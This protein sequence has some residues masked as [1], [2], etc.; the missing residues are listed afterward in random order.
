MKKFY[1]ILSLLFLTIV[2]FSITS[3]VLE[4]NAEAIRPRYIRTTSSGST[5][6]YIGQA[7][8]NRSWDYY[9]L[10]SDI[11]AAAD[12]GITTSAWKVQ[13]DAGSID[14][15]FSDA[16]M[17]SLNQSSGTIQAAG[18]GTANMNTGITFNGGW[19]D[20]NGGISFPGYGGNDSKMLHRIIFRVENSAS[21]STGEFLVANRSGVGSIIIFAQSLTTFRVTI[22]NGTTYSTIVTPPQGIGVGDHIL[23]I[24]TTD[25]ANS[26]VNERVNSEFYMDGTYVGGAEHTSDLASYPN[27]DGLSLGGALSTGTTPL[28][29]RTVFFIGQ[30]SG[31][32]LN[33]WFTGA[34]EHYADCVALGLCIDRATNT[35]RGINRGLPPGYDSGITNIVQSSL[36]ADGRTRTGWGVVIFSGFNNTTS[37]VLYVHHCGCSYN[38]SACRGAF[39]GAATTDP[40][41]EEYDTNGVHVYMDP[42]YT[43][44]TDCAVAGGGNGWL[45]SNSTNGDYQLMYEDAVITYLW[46]TFNISQTFCV[47]RSNGASWCN[48]MGAV[49]PYLYS[50]VV[51]TIGYLPG[52]LNGG[53]GMTATIAYGRT[54]IYVSHNSNDPTVAVDYA[55]WTVPEALQRN[56]GIDAGPNP[57]I[58]GGKGWCI[59]T[60]GGTGGVTADG[61]I[62]VTCGCGA[63]AS[64]YDSG[65]A[66]G[67]C[68][69]WGPSL[70]NAAAL[71]GATPKAVMYCE[72]RTGGHVTQPREGT[73]AF[74]DFMNQNAEDGGG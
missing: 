53:A 15:H 22:A 11:S 45:R 7:T 33:S 72:P 12:G 67:L 16:D 74:T 66:V 39:S 69:Y 60:D 44:P 1:Y 32:N 17:V 71:D 37:H 18:L 49:R 54:P 28:L 48:W 34:S 43:D 56:L 19:W 26:G 73:R 25:S 63:D 46:S 47:G 57:S 2:G 64:N 52:R 27:I 68:C 58:D 14:A 50:G 23:D 8:L 10:S 21:A 41:T 13:P 42:L 62:L 38:G 5:V 36:I 31:T 3:I 51:D 40:N 59:G 20:K 9:F 35:S 6:N 4:N 65:G 29:G 55:R 30:A 24:Y 70:A 61:S